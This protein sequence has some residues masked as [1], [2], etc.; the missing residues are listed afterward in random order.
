MEFQGI[1]KLIIIMGIALVAI[2]LLI[3]F[4]PR[5][6]LIGKLPGD[7]YF[8]RGDA[9]FYFPLASSIL[10]SVVLSMI[11]SIVFRGK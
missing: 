2:G 8:K 1:G 11:L 5:I 9:S 7:F 3:T 6:P 10:V 4:A